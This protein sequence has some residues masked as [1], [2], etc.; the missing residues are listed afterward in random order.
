M[1]CNGV[2]VEG[3]LRFENGKYCEKKVVVVADEGVY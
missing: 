2:M 1:S 3:I